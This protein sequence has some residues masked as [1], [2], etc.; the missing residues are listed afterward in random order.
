MSKAREME[1]ELLGG[2]TGDV[3]EAFRTIT[4]VVVE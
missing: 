1:D 4:S 2:N 3:A